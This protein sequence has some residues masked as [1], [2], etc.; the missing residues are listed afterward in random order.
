MLEVGVD[1]LLP[2]EAAPVGKHEGFPVCTDSR[3]VRRGA[4]LHGMGL[5]VRPA[6]SWSRYEVYSKDRLE[7]D[8]WRGRS[9]HAKAPAGDPR[10]QAAKCWA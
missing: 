9:S 4:G 10:A 7:D 2:T 5:S 3:C 8:A 1:G 6:S